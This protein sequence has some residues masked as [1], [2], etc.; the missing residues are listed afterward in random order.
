MQEEFSTA[1]TNI[2]LYDQGVSSNQLLQEKWMYLYLEKGYL[3]NVQ[4]R[5]QL[6]IG[7]C[8]RGGMLDEK[9][10]LFGFRTNLKNNYYDQ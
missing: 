2:F 9:Y 10:F 7:M 5:M 8:F 4:T 3:L 6:Y 1:G